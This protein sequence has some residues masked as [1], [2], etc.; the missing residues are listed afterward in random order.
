MDMATR[1][2]TLETSLGNVEVVE[3]EVVGFGGMVKEGE[4]PGPD[5]QL[6][7]AEFDGV[8]IAFT[9]HGDFL[10]LSTEE[11]LQLL[12]PE[13]KQNRQAALPPPPGPTRPQPAA[14]IGSLR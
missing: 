7:Y 12:P 8:R 13:F 3:S 1:R 14:G 5:R 2:V 6:L 4:L 9:C 10:A 11:Q